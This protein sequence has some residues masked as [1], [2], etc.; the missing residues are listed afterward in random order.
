M[1]R[2][3][4]N[5]ML[6]YDAVAK[7]FRCPECAKTFEKSS[8]FIVH[9]QE[10]HSPVKTMFFCSGC[11]VEFKRKHTLKCH[12]KVSD[13]SSARCFIYCKDE[14]DV[15]IAIPKVV[16]P[17][18]VDK[19]IQ[20]YITDC[21]NKVTKNEYAPEEEIKKVLDLSSNEGRFLLNIFFFIYKF[22]N[23]NFEKIVASTSLKSLAPESS[24]SK[25]PKST[26]S[27]KS[28]NWAKNPRISNFIMKIKDAISTEEKVTSFYNSFKLLLLDKCKGHEGVSE[29]CQLAKKYGIDMPKN[30]ASN[31]ESEGDMQLEQHGHQID[32]PSNANQNQHIEEEYELEYDSEL[33]KH[34]TS[35]D[36]SEDDKPLKQLRNEKNSPSNAI[37]NQDEEYEK[38]LYDGNSETGEDGG[39][40]SMNIDIAMNSVRIKINNIFHSHQTE[41]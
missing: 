6:H 29:A 41:Y 15:I 40:N 13:H 23:S 12:V 38:L 18:G 2:K 26:K 20:Q 24:K 28:D 21:E 35:C 3:N 9:R 7:L 39:L 14:L 36:G 17:N 37:Q 5:S 34:I 25:V 33:P 22:Q 30:V 16:H 11:G 1:P 8:N 27:S 32:T 4:N 10:N 31:E 19:F